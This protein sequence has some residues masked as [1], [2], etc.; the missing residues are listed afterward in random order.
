MTE[1]KTLF[2]RMAVDGL[3]AF[4]VTYRGDDGG[5]YVARYWAEDAGGAGEQCD[6]DGEGTYTVL[7]V[8]TQSEY[9]ARNTD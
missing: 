5:E 7:L 6:Q 4:S 8:E 3:Q 2:E 1:M 9:E